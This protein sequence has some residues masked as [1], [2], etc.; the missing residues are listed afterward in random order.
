MPQ[1]A[2][3]S[4]QNTPFSSMADQ[5]YP[6]N[7]PQDQQEP[8]DQEQG[9]S[10][11]QGLNGIATYTMDKGDTLWG[12]SQATG[13]PLQ[14]LQDAN[15][16]VGDPAKIPA[17]TTLHLPFDIQSHAHA[18]QD[19]WDGTQ[20]PGASNTGNGDA[21][22]Q[23]GEAKPAQQESSVKSLTPPG[24]ADN[25]PV[26]AETARK[27]RV[28]PGTTWR[29]LNL[30]QGNKAI[31]SKIVNG[32]ATR[33]DAAAFL[34]ECWKLRTA[35]DLTFKELQN[36][37]GI[38]GMF[39]SSAH[40]Q[41]PGVDHPNVLQSDKDVTDNPLY[42]DDALSTPSGGGMG[43][44]PGGPVGGGMILP[45]NPAL[46]RLNQS[47]GLSLPRSPLPKNLPAPKRKK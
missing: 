4:S 37:R 26:D 23:T 44:L 9:E 41:V 5:L 12:V 17:G 46:I 29:I 24:V 22:D 1:D 33:A 45:G 13:I 3:S 20:A 30:T 43:R 11:Q 25:Q 32:T 15:P 27:Y 47:M 31:Y 14:D 21:G 2:N 6:Q 18:T 40:P 19:V 16:H 10:I 7:A 36:L 8:P 38:V 34:N 39:F 42:I 28:E 35:P